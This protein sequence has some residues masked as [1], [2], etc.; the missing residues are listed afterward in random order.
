MEEREVTRRAM[1]QGG[2]ALAGLAALGAPMA[3]LTATAAP[4]EEILPW[5][6]QPAPNPIPD[7]VEDLLVWED[8]D[9]WITP[10]EKFFA[11]RHYDK[12][13]I[14]EQAWRLE[15]TGLVHRPMTLTLDALKAR[16]HH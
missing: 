4:G 3:A 14:G 5:L 15:V 6:D 16:R 13:T 8:L 7:I 11:V 1:L 10:T 9:T 12:P 2:A